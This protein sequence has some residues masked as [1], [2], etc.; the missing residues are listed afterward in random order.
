MIIPMTP[1]MVVR[2]RLSDQSCQ[3]LLVGPIRGHGQIRLCIKKKNLL[4][5]AMYMLKRICN[6]NI[7]QMPIKILFLQ[8]KLC[9]TNCSLCVFFHRVWL[10]YMYLLMYKNIPTYSRFKIQ[11]SKWFIWLTNNTSSQHHIHNKINEFST[12]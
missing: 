4:I 5:K 7:W 8:S 9:C 1:H 6:K 11:D 2:P 10:T 3:R 12:Y